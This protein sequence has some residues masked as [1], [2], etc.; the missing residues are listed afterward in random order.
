VNNAIHA[1]RE[2]ILRDAIAR[3]KVNIRFRKVS[4]KDGEGRSTGITFVDIIISDNG[5]GVPLEWLENVGVLGKSTKQGGSG[6][7]V[8]AAKEYF[9]AVGGALSW[10]NIVDESGSRVGFE[11]IARAQVFD[12]NRHVVGSPAELYKRSQ[13]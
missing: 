7:G 13:R 4:E 1:T 3:G 8:A 2:H 12:G 9:D 6:F 5:G 10:R 11:M